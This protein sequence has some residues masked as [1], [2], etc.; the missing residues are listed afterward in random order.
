M[1]GDDSHN[2]L[3]RGQP[4][5]FGIPG[6]HHRWALTGAGT[7]AQAARPHHTAAHAT[8]GAGT[9]LGARGPTSEREFE[10][11]TAGGPI[12]RLT[13]DRVQITPRGVNVVERHLARFPADQDNAGM[14]QRLREVAA[15]TL[16]PT[17]WDQRFYTHE[18][19]EFVRYRRLGWP[20]SEPADGEA[21]RTLWND[22][23]T[24]TLEDYGLKGRI[25]DLYHP[26]WR[27]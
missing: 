20:D 3:R 4:I 10:L 5:P 17:G 21:A 6:G 18:L 16:E 19:R 25:T 7:G 27:H 1:T 11:A 8:G 24:A 2:P 22:T 13:L 26:D 15:G 14:V 23:H 12:R 9:P